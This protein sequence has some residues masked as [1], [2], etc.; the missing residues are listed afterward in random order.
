LP[1]T[2]PNLLSASR[3]ALAPVLLALAWGGLPEAFLAVLAAALLTDFLDGRL[4]RRLGQVS[5]RGAELDSMGDLCI[6]LAVPVAAWWL[7]PEALL[8]DPISV[9]VIVASYTLT[10]A[11]GFLRYGRVKSFSTWSGRVSAFVLSVGAIL[12]LIDASIWPLRVSA[13]VV[14]LSD[15][16]EIAIMAL[17]PHWRANVPSLWHAAR[18]EP[19]RT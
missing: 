18:A 19:R 1:V 4:A 2:L 6:Y 5:D 10:S 13:G 17:L 9:A 12:L 15:L 16:E 11:V 14:V 3:I 8:R 7:W